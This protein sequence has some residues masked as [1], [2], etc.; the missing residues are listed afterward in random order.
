[1]VVK[2]SKEITDYKY[3]VMFDLASKK[4]G[5]CLYDIYKNE[6]IHTSMIIV[7]NHELGIVDLYNLID[8]YFKKLV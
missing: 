4:T 2:F 5:V 6:P 3:L 8:E 1:M 7:N